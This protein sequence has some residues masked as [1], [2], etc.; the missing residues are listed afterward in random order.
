MTDVDKIQAGLNWKTDPNWNMS[1]VLPTL[2]PTM[3]VNGDADATLEFKFNSTRQYGAEGTQ[4][5]FV[6]AKAKHVY[7][8][9]TAREISGRFNP[10][11][12]GSPEDAKEM[13]QA[14]MRA[15]DF[16]SFEG[17]PA[18]WRYSQDVKTE[19]YGI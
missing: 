5:I 19:N 16:N 1:A 6:K 9:D 2:T 3:I 15:Y 8:V 18:V 13:M 11:W 14:V 17:G 7:F 12:F 10:K 4:V